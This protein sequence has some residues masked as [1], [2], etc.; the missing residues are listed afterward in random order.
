[1]NVLKREKSVNVLK[2]WWLTVKESEWMLKN[3]EMEEWRKMKWMLEWYS[4]IENEKNVCVEM[5]KDLKSVKC[6]RKMMEKYGSWEELS[7]T[8]EFCW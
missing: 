4:V 3:D 1:M 8:Y 2:E 6:R 7:G 5:L